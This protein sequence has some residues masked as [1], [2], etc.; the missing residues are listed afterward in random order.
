LIVTEFRFASRDAAQRFKSATIN[1]VFLPEDEASD[2]PGPEIDK[3]EPYGKWLM[4]HTEASTSMSGTSDDP[5][6]SPGMLNRRESISS[7]ATTRAARVD[8]KFERIVDHASATEEQATLMGILRSG[9]QFDDENMATWYLEENPSTKSGIPTVFKTAVLLKRASDANFVA[10]LDVQAE[11][12]FRYQISAAF[13]R[14]TM[15][16][17][18]NNAFHFNMKESRGSIDVKDINA[19]DQV[20]LTGYTST[21]PHRP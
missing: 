4:E 5:S 7:F 1:Y 19:L 21:K 6:P 17:L 13:N 18:R 15:A 9:N 2:E 3:I 11:V 12:D 10:T 8:W 20:E 14:L 16:G